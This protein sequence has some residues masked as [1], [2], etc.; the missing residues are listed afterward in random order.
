MYYVIDMDAVREGHWSAARDGARSV[1]GCGV[2]LCGEYGVYLC[3]F[4]HFSVVQRAF[5]IVSL[6]IHILYGR[7]FTE[8]ENVFGILPNSGNESSWK[9]VATYHIIPSPPR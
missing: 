1:V 6:H 9:N 7:V 8:L 3:H 4:D 5:F 2:Y